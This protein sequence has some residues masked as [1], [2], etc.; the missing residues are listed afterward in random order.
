MTILKYFQHFDQ[1]LKHN[2]YISV[3]S[4]LANIIKIQIYRTD[5]SIT[6]NK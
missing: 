6:V 1:S 5:I 2:I 4:F 3:T